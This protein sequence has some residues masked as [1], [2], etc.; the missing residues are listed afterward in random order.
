VRCWCYPNYFV[1]NYFSHGA[2][3]PSGPWSPDCRG[4]EVTLRHTTISS[5]PLDGWSARCRNLY[6][7]TWDDSHAPSEFR[8]WNPRKRTAQDHAWN[9]AA[10]RKNLCGS[11]LAK[12]I[13][14][15]PYVIVILNGVIMVIL[16]IKV[17]DKHKLLKILITI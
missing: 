12:K 4:Y 17:G 6:L 1:S 3:A 15:I 5:T 16:G 9:S 14:T 2:T 8:T 13:N 10:T 11:L 7:T